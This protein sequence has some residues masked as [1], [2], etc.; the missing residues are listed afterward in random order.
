MEIIQ[1][2]VEDFNKKNTLSYHAEF[3]KSDGYKLLVTFRRNESGDSFL[4]DDKIVEFLHSLNTQTGK[5][6]DLVR[7]FRREDNFYIAVFVQDIDRLK[8]VVDFGFPPF[9]LIL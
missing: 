9:D 3:T 2:I 4:I 7:L 1:K 6:F 8:E 5:Q